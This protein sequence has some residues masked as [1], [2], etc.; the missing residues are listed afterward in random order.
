VNLS[1]P[2][3]SPFPRPLRVLLADDTMSNR[4][5]FRSF[6]ERL[7]CE[8]E[9]ACDGQDALERFTRL[10][11]DLV[12]LDVEMPRLGGFEAA[13]AMRAQLGGRWLP[14]VFL[15]TLDSEADFI[16]G[17]DAGAD[18]FLHKP[19]TL[20]ILAAKLR[21]LV[22]SLTLHRAMEDARNR[23]RA[24]TDTLVDGVVVADE[25]G[26]IEWC[27]PAALRMFG[28]AASELI[29]QRLEVL[30]PTPYRTEHDGY[31]KRYLG[32]ARPRII[33]VGQRELSGARKD[34]TT[35]PMGLG[36]ADVLQGERRLFVGI[37]RDESQRKIAEEQ[38]RRHAT[39][40]ESLFNESAA[41][42]DLVRQVVAQQH[43]RPALRHARVQRLS[44]PAAKFG[45][46]VATAAVGP[47]D[48][49]VVLLAH[50]ASGG[51]TGA[52]SLLPLLTIFHHRATQVTGLVALEAE[53]RA[54]LTEVLPRARPIG[55]S[56]ASI[57]SSRGVA[58][59]LVSG[60][61]AAL[62]FAADGQVRS[63]VEQ[64]LFEAPLSEGGQVALMSPGLLGLTRSETPLDELAASVRGLEPGRRFEVLRERLTRSLPAGFERPD[65][66]LLLID[67]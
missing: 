20:T 51:L 61:P 5:L 7:G 60:L 64:G 59:V 40:A 63:R 52:V 58:S 17:L 26:V 29:G 43:E 18:E 4:L 67:C 22:R 38:A 11:C 50:A 65:A 30:M 46:D 48:R 49:L 55:L 6:L 41:R 19:V 15:T 54:A 35:F 36:V 25:R 28:Y 23:E 33:G 44:L 47:D 57:D 27:N 2:L 62:V 3:V 21:A 42:Q 9:E 24:I 13:R 14:I 37:C 12:L 1:T 31:M 39:R 34:G 10:E 66:T 16:E 56:L 32:G 45:G 8:V 53:L